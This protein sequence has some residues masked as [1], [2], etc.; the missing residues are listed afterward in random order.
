MNMRNLSRLLLTS[1]DNSLV[2]LLEKKIKQGPLFI[3]WDITNRCNAKCIMCDQWRPQSINSEM[4]IETKIRIIKDLGK[5]GVGLLSL[6]GGEPFL[7]SNLRELIRAA[8][9][10]GLL[11]NVTTNGSLIMENLDLIEELDFLIIGVDS[12]LGAT[13]DYIR[14]MPGLFAKLNDSIDIIMAFQKRPVI[15]IRSIV[16]K[17]NIKEIDKFID[18]WKN[19]V[20]EII[21]QPFHYSHGDRL[22]IP[23]EFY[24]SDIT[25][26]TA[27]RAGNILKKHK[28]F[29]LYN[30][31]MLDY[32][33]DKESLKNKFGCFCGYFV[34]EIDSNGILWNCSEHKYKLGD[35][36]EETLLELMKKNKQGMKAFSKTRK[37]ICWKN[38]AMINVYLTKVLGRR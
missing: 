34:L 28:P 13:H 27:Y 2:Y 37:C 20:D 7:E 32:L 36:K 25:E 15:S 26:L 33:L 5:S 22:K 29:K 31:E 12:Y 21:F 38:S 17:P 35:L 9:E 18:Y 19:R 1:I 4:E 3:S 6:C 24:E 30:R 8:K 11:I 10:A 16:T 23:E 14:G